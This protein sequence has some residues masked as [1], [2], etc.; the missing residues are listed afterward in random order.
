MFL[1]HVLLICFVGKS[2]FPKNII[3]LCPVLKV[4]FGV[5]I[6]AISYCNMLNN[7][8]VIF[9]E[10]HYVSLSVMKKF[11]LPVPLIFCNLLRTR[12]GIMH[13]ADPSQTAP[14]IRQACEGV[15]HFLDRKGWHIAK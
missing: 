1:F 3:L 15:C 9:K 4:S 5:K 12:I 11:N 10:D 7:L 14:I 13:I 2:V 8:S 6:S